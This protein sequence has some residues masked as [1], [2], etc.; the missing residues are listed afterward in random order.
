MYENLESGK[1]I[2]FES[3]SCEKELYNLLILVNYEYLT[4]LN[5]KDFFIGV[6]LVNLKEVEKMDYNSYYG[7]SNE[8]Q[9][10][11]EK[12]HFLKTIDSKIN[13]DKRIIFDIIVSLYK[14]LIY[15]FKDNLNKSKSN[16]I[17]NVYV[18]FILKNFVIFLDQKYSKQLDINPNLFELLKI[19]YKVNIEDL[20]EKKKYPTL[21]SLYKFEEIDEIL[22][23][24][25]LVSKQYKIIKEELSNNKHKKENFIKSYWK[26]GWKWLGYEPTDELYKYITYLSLKQLKFIN[27][28][29]ITI[30][31][32]GFRTQNRNEMNQW[33]NL[34]GFLNE[35]TIIYFYKWPSGNFGFN[36]L[37]HFSNSKE[38]AKYSG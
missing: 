30:L 7:F 16:N 17:D 36:M 8:S 4:R 21:K 18:N 11:L 27:S 12:S 38:R 13:G 6:L 23:K 31:I 26:K 33:R 22:S 32:D 20:V 3:V 29:T 28:N 19:L 25:E 5:F 37:N 10:K 1:N 14:K 34:I 2:P 24:N 9:I 35:D 15:E